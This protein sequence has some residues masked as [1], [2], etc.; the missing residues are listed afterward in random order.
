MKTDEE[1]RKLFE[2]FK[3]KI[4]SFEEFESLL[5]RPAQTVSELILEFIGEYPGNSLED[6]RFISTY[7]EE[8]LLLEDLIREVQAGHLFAKPDPQIEKRYWITLD[9]LGYWLLRLCRSPLKAKACENMIR[10]IKKY[11]AKEPIGIPSAIARGLLKKE[12][13]EKRPDAQESH[14]LSPPKQIKKAIKNDPELLPLAESYVRSYDGQEKNAWDTLVKLVKKHI[15]QI[16]E[17][18]ELDKIAR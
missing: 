9:A 2:N 18:K 12:L 10:F 15:S 11:I 8:Y 17:S 4:K 5:L 6:L 3:P 16:I 7:P 14:S 1:L 13:L